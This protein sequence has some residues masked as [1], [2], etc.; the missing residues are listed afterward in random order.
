M[1]LKN[2]ME[3]TARFIWPLALLVSATLYGA[4]ESNKENLYEFR[5]YVAE[6]YTSKED[7]QTMFS[8]LETNIDKRLETLVNTLKQ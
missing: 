5:L 2:F 1:T 3:I 7:L 6:H 4:T 8:Q